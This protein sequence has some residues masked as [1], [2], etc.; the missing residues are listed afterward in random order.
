MKLYIVLLSHIQTHNILSLHKLLYSYLI[1]YI[2]HD[3]ITIAI[4]NFIEISCQYN[5]LYNILQNYI[6]MAI[7]R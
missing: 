1:K 7:M 5:S 4:N 3:V 2:S 6:F